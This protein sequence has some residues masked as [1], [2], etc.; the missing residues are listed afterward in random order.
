MA[1]ILVFGAHPDDAEIGAGGTIAR[2]C[3]LGYEVVI[4]DISGGEMSTNGDPATRSAE[5]REAARR[6]G[7]AARETLGLADRALEP[8]PERV[9]VVVEAIRRWRPAVVL[10]PWPEDRHPD[11]AAAARLVGQAVFDAGLVRFQGAGAP[12]RTGAVV[13][14]FVNAR[15]EPG[16]VVDVSD[17][18]S[19]KKAAL[20]AYVSQFGGSAA[21]DPATGG[22]AVAGP[23]AAGASAA[24]GQSHRPTPLNQGY[25]Q[26]VELRD[27]WYG[28]LAGVARAEGFVRDG[29]LAVDDLVRA[30][31]SG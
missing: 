8:T 28:S 9:R 1:D 12:H 19:V 25:L 23:A 11:H 13:W 7:V 31:K 10:A 16:F 15:R 6:L 26:W 3:R 14:Y 20:A 21:N 27:S 22:S 30:L 4:C 18:Y 5:A 2:H 29:V 24:A 17:V